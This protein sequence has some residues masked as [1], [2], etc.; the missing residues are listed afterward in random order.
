M[1]IAALPQ[2]IPFRPQIQREEPDIPSS[3]HRR[4]EE[5]ALRTVAM[6]I[7]YSQGAKGQAGLSSLHL[8]LLRLE[9][10]ALQFLPQLTYDERMDFIAWAARLRNVTARQIESL[11]DQASDIMMLRE[12]DRLA[13][14]IDDMSE[15]Q[16]K[17]LFQNQVRYQRSAPRRRMSVFQETYA[18]K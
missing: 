12:L 8:E 10:G 14:V 7:R 9:R 15:S 11:L 17:R 1:A 4:T 18:A 16:V 5:A 3:I 2:Y 13:T 6:R